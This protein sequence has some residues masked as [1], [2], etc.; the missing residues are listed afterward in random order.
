MGVNKISDFGIILFVLPCFYSCMRMD[1]V[2]CMLSSSSP[3]NW[4]FHENRPDIYMQ[5]NKPWPS[6][7]CC[8]HHNR[9]GSS[10]TTEFIM[11]DTGQVNELGLASEGFPCFCVVQHSGGS[12]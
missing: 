7:F 10:P 12:F 9:V 4:I 8:G 11:R 1:S 3:V 2:S 6:P 5:I